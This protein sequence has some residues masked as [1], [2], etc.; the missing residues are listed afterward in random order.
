MIKSV[1][2]LFV[3]GMS[4][5]AC[6]ADDDLDT[7]RHTTCIEQSGGVTVEMLNCID[8]ELVSQ[9]ARLNGAYQR[10]KTQLTPARK[11]QLVAVQRLWI[12]YRDANCKFYA[13][14]DGGTFANLNAND[15]VLR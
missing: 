12:Q 14:P 13:D 7:G 1:L 5:F 4:A 10:L 2:I 11:Q 9:D 15:C 8:E 3:L 6:L